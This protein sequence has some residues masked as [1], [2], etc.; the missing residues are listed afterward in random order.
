[1]GSRRRHPAQSLANAL[2]IDQPP[3]NAPTP[4]AAPSLGWVDLG[5]GAMRADGAGARAAAAEAGWAL[6]LEHASMWCML[7]HIAFVMWCIVH[8]IEV[9]RWCIVHHSEGTMVHDA[10][11]NAASRECT[12]TTPVEQV[13]GPAKHGQKGMVWEYRI[14]RPIFGRFLHSLQRVHGRGPVGQPHQ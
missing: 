12:P 10:P 6:A 8:Q 3:A 4:Q 7:H 9:L 5:P 13:L 2:S 11:P 1:M 14:N